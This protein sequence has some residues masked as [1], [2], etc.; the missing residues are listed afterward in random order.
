MIAKPFTYVAPQK[1]DEA[2]SLLKNCL[3]EALVLGG[4]TMLVPAMTREESRP[5]LV[6]DL[7]RIGLKGIFE[8]RGNII[9]EAR[10]SYEDVLASALIAE[11]APLLVQMASGVTGGRS[12]TGQGTLVGSAF[13]ANP[14]SDVPACLAALGARIRLVGADGV[15]EVA[16]AEFFLGGFQTSRR[17]DEIG[18]ALILPR[19]QGRVSTSY[20][21]VKPSGSSWPIITVACVIEEISAGIATISLAI[22]GLASTPLHISATVEAVSSRAQEELV[23]ALVSNVKSPWEDALA[24]AEYRS[25]VAPAIALRV[26]REALGMHHG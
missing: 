12:I 10:A 24:D 3:G 11:Q 15:R 5:E 1:V 9:I 20:R 18:M 22:G 26:M 19:P 16:M 6:V 13:F 8:E 23:Y 17:Q 7:R 14:A 2:V 4:G 25:R 21:K